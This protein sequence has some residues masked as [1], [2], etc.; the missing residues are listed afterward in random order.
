MYNALILAIPLLVILTVFVLGSLPPRLESLSPED[1]RDSAEYH[2]RMNRK[3]VYTQPHLTPVV[4]VGT[5][6]LKQVF[7][8]PPRQW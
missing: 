4:E 2:T 6:K 1:M 3:G 8:L 5:A 7:L